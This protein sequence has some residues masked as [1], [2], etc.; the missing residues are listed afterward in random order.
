ML[1]KLVVFFLVLA[2]AIIG[3]THPVYATSNTDVNVSPSFQKFDVAVKLSG[4]AVPEHLLKFSQKSSQFIK[5]C[6]LSQPSSGIEE[7]GCGLLKTSI[8]A[9]IVVVVCY[10]ADGV[11]TSVLPPLAALA[12]ICSYLGAAKAGEKAV[13][14]IIH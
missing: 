3:S 7:I 10:S 14:V 11:A 8:Q 12:P 1:R 9:G 6:L 4:T 2:V 13:D 5:E